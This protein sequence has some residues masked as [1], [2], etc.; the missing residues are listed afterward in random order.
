MKG[1]LFSIVFFISISNVFSQEINFIK[2]DWDAARKASKEKNKYIFMDAY[3]NWCSWCKVMDKQTFPDPAVA[4]FMNQNF[5]PLKMEMET[6]FGITLSMKYRVTG[7]PTFLVFNTEGKLVYKIVGY[8]KPAEFLIE[9]K[10]ALNKEKQLN[11]KGVT[12][13]IELAFPDIYKKSFGKGIEKVFPDSASVIKYLDSQKDLFSELSWAVYSRFKSSIKYNDNF[14]NNLAKYTELFGKEDV[15]I[16]LN[17]LIYRE[18][19][20]GVKTKS[21]QYLDVVLGMIDK[22]ITENKEITKS[23]Y[24]ISYYQGLGDWEK[25]TSA[26]DGFIS[27]SGDDIHASINEFAWNVFENSEDPAAIKTATKWMKNMTEKHPEYAY[28]DTYASLLF[29]IKDYDNA[30]KIATKAIEIG[31]ASEQKVGDTEELLG[32]IKKAKARNK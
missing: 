31:K 19:E 24:R 13:V 27:K 7:F 28:L 11:L 2:Q 25:Y 12:D 32:R 20:K 1:I 9:L 22:Y 6:G 26:V 5:V 10:N 14:L 16:Q 23:Q 15:N 8:Q 17:S 18:L 3:T 29:K 4:E 21:E 30:E